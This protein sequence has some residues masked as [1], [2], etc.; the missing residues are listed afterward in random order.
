MFKA[1]LVSLITLLSLSAVA[2]H[3]VP[4]R[5]AEVDVVD[6]RSG[7]SLP[8]YRHDGRWYVAGEPGREYEVRVRSRQP[9]RLLA[10]ASVDGV[11]VVT[12]ETAHPRQSGYVLDAYGE[13]Q[14]DGWRKSMNRVARFYFTDL[15]DSYAARTDRPDDVGVIGIALFKEKNHYRAPWA[16][17]AERDD[18]SPQGAAPYSKSERRSA[19]PQLG[20]GHGRSERSPVR[21]TEFERASGRPDE[22]VTIYYDSYRNLQARGVVPRERRWASAEPRAFPGRFV[23]DPWR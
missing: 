1:A 11:N 2:S 14:I 22:V 23:P 12:G 13:T 7:K 20:T 21:Y 4:G 6:A 9:Q 10:V 18:R 16:K 5:M 3:D 15:G 8:L 19:E 17:D